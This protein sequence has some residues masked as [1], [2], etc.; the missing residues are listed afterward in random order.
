MK[1][2]EEAANEQ[3]CLSPITRIVCAEAVLS[4]AALLCMPFGDWL[5]WPTVLTK[6]KPPYTVVNRK[7][8]LIEALVGD[9]KWNIEKI[10]WAYFGKLHTPIKLLL[11]KFTKVSFLFYWTPLIYIIWLW[12]KVKKKILL[13]PSVYYRKSFSGWRD[14]DSKIS[15][16]AKFEGAQRRC[17]RSTCVLDKLSRNY[18]Y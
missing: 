4:S 3:T 17:G 8:R 5:I 2:R 10:L 18:Y 6:N 9:C 13:L 14:G 7:T 16:R 11:V 15:G 1:L 12:K